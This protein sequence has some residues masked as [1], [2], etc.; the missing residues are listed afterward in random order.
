MCL[1]CSSYIGDSCLIHDQC[2]TDDTL[3]VSEE[4]TSDRSKGGAH[5]DVGVGEETTEAWYDSQSL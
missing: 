5:G 2:H 4:E 3:V 1:T